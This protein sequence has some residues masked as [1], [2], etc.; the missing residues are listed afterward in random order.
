MTYATVIIA[1]WNAEDSLERSVASAL[2]QVGVQLEVI[3]VDDASGDGTLALAQAL[4]GNDP[5]V[6]VVAQQTNGGPAAARNAGIAVARG[7]WIAVLDAD[8]TMVEDRL[9]AMID[10]AD[11]TGA[12]AIYD[13]VQPVD[14]TG[15]ALGSPFVPPAGLDGAE[16][17][18]TG[19]ESAT[20]W[21]LTDYLRGN[22]VRADRPG[23]G[24]L[25]PVL[26]A[27][28]LR[29]HD[30]RYDARLRNG[31][32][33]H[34]MLDILVEGGALWFTPTAGY[35]Y[36]RRPGSVS[37]RLNQDH[38]KALAA[39]D[40]AFLDRHRS[41]LEREDIALLHR[42]RQRLDDLATAEVTLAALKTGRP[43]QALLAICHRPRAM[44]R[45]I[46]QL[47]EAVRRRLG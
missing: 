5:R 31:E 45:L 44:G 4:A 34:L 33:Y 36:T 39:A 28:F 24:Y 26:R 25:K 43:A 16:Q 7:R 29:D 6:R 38:A 18:G 10:L 23:L 13:N 41:R 1:A 19:N 42:R 27:G 40:R 47:S 8:D 2:A 12:D 35:L 21:T 46:R 20:R 30:I 22:Q 17:N 9:R 37:S 3:V 15:A 14:L 11:R 32:D